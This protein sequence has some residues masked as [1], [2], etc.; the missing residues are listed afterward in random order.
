MLIFHISIND[1]LV[2]GDE[3]DIVNAKKTKAFLK[4][5]IG[6]VHALK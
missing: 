5:P 3:L 2:S 1:F 4:K 6:S